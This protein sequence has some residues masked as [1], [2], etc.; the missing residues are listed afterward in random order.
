MATASLVDGVALGGCWAWSGSREAK[1]DSGEGE[2]GTAASG[3]APLERTPLDRSDAVQ[4]CSG[5]SE[6]AGVLRA[7]TSSP[8]WTISRSQG[9]MMKLSVSKAW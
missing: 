9:R 8:P 7:D 5:R 1:Q 6:P 2:S 3:G 4:G